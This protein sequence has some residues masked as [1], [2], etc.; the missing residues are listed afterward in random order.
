[1]VKAGMLVDIICSQQQTETSQLFTTTKCFSHETAFYYENKHK[2]PNISK[3]NQQ[4]RKE[5]K[6]DVEALFLFRGSVFI[7]F[8]STGNP[9]NNNCNNQNVDLREQLHQIETETNPFTTTTPL[10]ARSR[11]TEKASSLRRIEKNRLNSLKE[12]G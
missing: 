6:A 5:I 11:N 4:Q 3:L 1:M 12:I 9:E 10:L 2:M 8:I 7:C